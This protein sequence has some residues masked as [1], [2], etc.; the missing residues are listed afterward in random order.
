[1]ATRRRHFGSVRR[2]PSGRWQAIYWHLG[3]LYVAPST[4]GVKADALAWLSATE[5]DVH[6]GSWVA[7]A[8]GRVSVAELASRWLDVDPGKRTN[9]RTR[10]EL[11]VRLHIVP[12]LGKARL[13]EV[14]QPAI[15]RLVNSWAKKRAPRMVHRD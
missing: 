8:G 4:F 1:M 12:V 6:R 5:T 14:T 2:L 11:V 13:N 15:Q 7:P 10:D 3:A 9:T